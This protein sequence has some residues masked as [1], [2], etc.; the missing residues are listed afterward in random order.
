MP[1]KSAIQQLS[2]FWGA[3]AILV[4]SSVVGGRQ[5][6]AIEVLLI[7]DNSNTGHRLA[8]FDPFDGS[9]VDLNFIT[10]LND[11]GDPSY[12]QTVAIS[13]FD[14]GRGT[15]VVTDQGGSIMEYNHDGTLANAVYPKQPDALYNIRGGDMLNGKVL[16]TNA[17]GLG[18][19]LQFRYRA[20]LVDID[21]G[22]LSLF[23]T[24]QGADGEVLSFDVLVRE[25]DVLIPEQYDTPGAQNN[26]SYVDSFPDGINQFSLIGGTGT[27]LFTSDET[28]GIDFPM[29]VN[30]AA[31]GDLLVG[32]FS[33]PSGIY[34]YDGVT[35]EQL[36]YWQAPLVRGVYELGNG[37]ILYTT[38]ENNSGVY[39]MDPATGL[40][41]VVTKQG[42]FRFI[43]LVD[44]PGLQ[45]LPGE[46]NDDGVVN[47]ADYTVWRDN[48]GR[49][50][51]TR[52]NGGGDGLNGVDAGDYLVWKDNFGPAG[53]AGIA[54]QATVPEPQAIALL[55]W[56]AIGL[57][58]IYRKRGIA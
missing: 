44:V 39:V 50:D 45:V 57:L 18:N 6:T 10:G 26:P 52:L 32:G 51:E 9:I 48:L 42:N 30:P 14:S 17:G 8:A 49:P 40:S 16:V 58:L 56:P 4:L 5:A 7:P 23:N 2:L 19:D 13:A 3:T 28:T 31:N 1:T 12:N 47:L 25:N 20:I 24:G 33:E 41:T 15:I 34:R 35:G 53:T 55:A 54:A 46:F 11:N 43:E 36:G 38:G 22:A 21:T 27:P 37:N 29:Q